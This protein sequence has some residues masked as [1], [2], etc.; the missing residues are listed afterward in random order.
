[1]LEK[2]SRWG[3]GNRGVNASVCLAHRG[4]VRTPSGIDSA[5]RRGPILGRS[6]DVPSHATQPITRATIRGYFFVDRTLPQFPMTDCNIVG[7]KSLHG[8]HDAR[9]QVSP[10]AC[11]LRTGIRRTLTFVHLSP[12]GGLIL[13]YHFSKGHGIPECSSLRKHI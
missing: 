4:E 7:D 6:N 1:M 3:G 5:G 12:N 13:M 10:L 2:S 9:G 11:G 8:F